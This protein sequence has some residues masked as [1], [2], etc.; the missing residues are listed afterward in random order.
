METELGCY[1]SHYGII[2]A[3]FILILLLAVFWTYLLYVSIYI[4]PLLILT[5]PF[6]PVVYIPI[7]V[8]A[9]REPVEIQVDETGIHIVKG[10]LLRKKVFIDRSEVGSVWV[11]EIRAPTIAYYIKLFLTTQ[12]VCYGCAYVEVYN[13]EG[14]TESF[15]LRSLE[16]TCFRE[17]VVNELGVSDYYE[18]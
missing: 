6:S 17:A 1:V 10:L 16:Y 14:S 2:G 15:V 5:V 13:K 3:Y 9:F 7:Y 11:E 4:K 18:L 8:I 12:L